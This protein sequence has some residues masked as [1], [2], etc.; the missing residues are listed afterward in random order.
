MS[1][2]GLDEGMRAHLE[3]PACSIYEL[4]RRSAAVRP[5]RLSYTYY[6]TGRTYAQLI[7]EIDACAGA[8]CAL[9]IGEGDVVSICMPNMP[10]A[11]TAFY[12]VNRLG[13]VANM[14]HPLS[15][16]AEIER[17]LSE[18]KS[19]ALLAVD[20]VLSRLAPSLDRLEVS[21]I[22]H[23][24]VGDSM[25]PLLRAGYRLTKK[26]QKAFADPRCISWKQLMKKRAPLPPHSGEGPDVADATAVILYSGGT[27][28]IPKG[29]ELTNLNF[30]ALALQGIEAC[31]CIGEGDRVL[32]VM[33]IFHGFGLGICIHT[34]QVMGG[35]SILLPAFRAKA[36]G[37]LILKYRPN[38]IAGVPTL[39]EA[40]LSTDCLKGKKLSFLKCV[41][42]GGDALPTGLKHKVDAFL[43]EHGAAVQVREGY[44]L[45]ECVTGSCLTPPDGYREGSIGL[46]YPDTLYR[47]VR[48]QTIEELPCGKEGEIVISGP[49]VMKGYL[50]NPEE[51]KKALRRHADGRLWLHT[52][53]LGVMDEDGYVYYRQRLKRMIISSGYNVYPGHIENVLDA[54]PEVLVS[55]V[56]GIPHPYRLQAAK[57]FIIPKSFDPTQE[58]NAGRVAELEGELRLLCERE[59][60]KYSWPVAYE[61][62]KE[63]PRTKV[64]KLAVTVLEEE[65]ARHAQ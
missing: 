17:I 39:Y 53:D 12:A 2:M 44:G 37:R 49:T 14:I 9:G 1:S 29:I 20:L 18:T 31:A 57:A 24:S 23:A 46:P 28:G 32:A 62:R 13:A 30:N 55:C 3:Y 51:T 35:C 33:P 58:R 27:S 7:G 16:V 19:R 45:T 65:E 40:L 36:F 64:G 10:E 47:I 38:I 11:M 48:P 25:P 54:H 43:A 6:G 8:L 15:G 56:I 21:H 4:V 41:I 50:G 34:V 42:S 63:L 59:L 22:I 5:E 60:P 26:P 52:G 61:F